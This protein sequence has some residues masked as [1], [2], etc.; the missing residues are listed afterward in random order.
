MEMDADD[1][2]A[3]VE[4]HNREIADL[5]DELHA[6]KEGQAKKDLEVLIRKRISDLEAD[7]KLKELQEKMAAEEAKREEAQ[8]KRRRF[9]GLW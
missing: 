6:L 3:A 8:R 2:Q 9:L 1:L 7:I 5:R 4:R